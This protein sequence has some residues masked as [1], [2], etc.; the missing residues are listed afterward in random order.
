MTNETDETEHGFTVEE[1]VAV[2]LLTQSVASLTSSVVKLT[3]KLEEVSKQS[4][5]N[6]LELA[7]ITSGKAT[8]MWLLSIIGIIWMATAGA[9]ESIGQLLS[10]LFT[11]GK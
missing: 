11:A 9:A 7:K 4:Q 2:A 6:G 8:M 10:K 3:E 1:K 5:K